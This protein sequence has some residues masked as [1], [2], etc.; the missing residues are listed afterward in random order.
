MVKKLDTKKNIQ[1]IKIFI[2]F[3]LFFLLL[4]SQNVLAQTIGILMRQEELAILAHTIFL[5][6]TLIMIKH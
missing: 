5:L 2:L 4:I 1:L 6:A 3:F